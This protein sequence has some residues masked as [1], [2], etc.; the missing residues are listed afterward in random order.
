MKG[1][2]NSRINRE[3]KGSQ[4]LKQ[5]SGTPFVEACNHQKEQI[6]EQTLRAETLQ[7]GL[8]WHLN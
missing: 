1:K 7:V 2:E 6:S 4:L 3:K 8:N 5:I